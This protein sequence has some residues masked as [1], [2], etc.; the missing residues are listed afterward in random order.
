MAIA[1]DVHGTGDGIG[2]CIMQYARDNMKRYK[3]FDD[4]PLDWIIRDYMARRVDLKS[5][6]M[7]PNI[8]QHNGT[9]SSLAKFHTHSSF[10]FKEDPTNSRA[11]IEESNYNALGL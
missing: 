4:S 7:M 2:G 5:L 6:L 9:V 10:A 3:R 8:V 1:M 11:A